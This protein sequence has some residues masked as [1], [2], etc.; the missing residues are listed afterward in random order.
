MKRQRV[1]A[2]TA[3]SAI[4]TATAL[5]FGS[6][7]ASADPLELKADEA[8]ADLLGNVS[9]GMVN[10]MSETFDLTASEVYERLAVESVASDLLEQVPESLD[11]TYAGLWVSDDAD[12]IMV[13]TTSKADTDELAAE[14]ATPVVVDHDMADLEAAIDVLDKVAGDD[15][16]GYYVDLPANTVVIEAADADSATDLAEA[17]GIDADMVTVDTTTEAPEPYYVRGGDAYY[18]N[19]SGRCSV[20]FAAR[21]GSTPGFLTAG[22]CGSTGARVTGGSAAPGTFRNSVF[23][24]N[25]A[26]WVEVG[27]GETLYNIVNM[28]SGSRYVYNSNRAAVG[29]SV[30]RSGSTTGWHCGTIQAFNQTVR[31]SQGSVYG[32]TRTSVCAEP[33]DSGGSFISGNSAQGMT[34]GGSGNCSWGGTTYFQPINP[35]LNAWNL[36]LV[37]S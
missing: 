20:G 7:P 16:Y 32:L 17:A 23:P 10:E 31:Y 25:D 37:T 35:A 3:A 18:I 26:A 13:A 5:T 28:Y 30:C 27:S 12:E 36:T 14:G 19:N 33:G 11:E 1:L 9:A 29:S 2:V 24:G 21:R 34:S 15:V 8:R 6:A 4:A 22:H